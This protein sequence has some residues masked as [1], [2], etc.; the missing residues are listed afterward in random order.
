MSHARQVIRDYV[1][2]QLAPIGVPIYIGK[3]WLEDATDLPAIN[4][5]TPAEGR[6]TEFARTTRAAPAVYAEVYGLDVEVEIRAIATT[7]ILD[8]LDDVAADVQAILAQDVTWGDLVTMLRL[9]STEVE[10]TSDLQMPTGVLTMSY[11]AN[12]TIDMRAPSAPLGG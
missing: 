12:Y 11:A 5:M 4:I 2:A 8:A 10:I 3:V 7:G 1:A 6:N 9:V